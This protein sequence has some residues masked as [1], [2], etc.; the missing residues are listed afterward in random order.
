MQSTPIQN[1]PQQYETNKKYQGLGSLGEL[2]TLQFPYLS[3]ENGQPATTTL[4]QATGFLQK[5]GEF[6]EDNPMVSLG[7]AG[8]LVLIA[9]RGG[10]R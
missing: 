4:N 2:V 1:L 9:M 7:I 10:R 5:V 8:V 3:N 6:V